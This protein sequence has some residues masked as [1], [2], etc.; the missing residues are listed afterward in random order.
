MRKKLCVTVVGLGILL[1]SAY[2]SIASMSQLEIKKIEDGVKKMKGESTGVRQ[3]G[4]K[5]LR[6]IGANCAPYVAEALTD[7]LV[8][9]PS[10]VMMCDLLGELKSKEALPALTATLRNQSP[11][12]R[13]A[14]ARAIGSVADLSSIE[15]LVGLLA[16]EDPHVREAAIDSLAAVNANEAPRITQLLKDEQENVRVAAIKFLNGRKDTATIQD[17]REAFTKDKSGNVRAIAARTIG[18][19]K[20]TAAVDALMI[21]VIE[22]PDNFVREECAASLG[23]IRDSKALPALIE[24]LKDDYK[25]IQLKAAS[26]LKEMTGQDFGKDYEKWLNWYASNKK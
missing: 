26:S 23:A 3:Q 17:I 14:A 8:V 9:S 10:K 13:A 1:A 4:Y 6:D 25:D 5:E 11:A 20:D 7:K 15:P 21:A 2:Q 22:D 18:E 19:M 24:A 12:I 16:D